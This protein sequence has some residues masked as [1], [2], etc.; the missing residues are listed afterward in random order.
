MLQAVKL[1][2]PGGLVMAHAKACELQLCPPDSMHVLPPHTNHFPEQAMTSR[3]HRVLR[4]LV[5][6]AMGNR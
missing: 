3:Q 5:Q 6:A 4:R 1:L 2:P